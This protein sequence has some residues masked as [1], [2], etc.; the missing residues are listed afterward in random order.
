ME[1]QAFLYE[2]LR[3]DMRFFLLSFFSYFL[4]DPRSLYRTHESTGHTANP[5][6]H[7]RYIMKGHDDEYV[8]VLSI[9]LVI[10]P[11]TIVCPLTVLYDTGIF[12]LMER[13]HH[14]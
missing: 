9:C 14:S 6:L 7:H 10:A 3:S 5:A 4:L 11:M 13:V 1:L 2:D 12:L 8:P